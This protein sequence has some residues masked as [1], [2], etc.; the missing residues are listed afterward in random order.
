MPAWFR[1]GLLAPWPLSRLFKPL[2]VMAGRRNPTIRAAMAGTVAVTSVGMFSRGRSGWGIAATP[3]PLGLVVGS[4]ALKPAVVGGRIEPREILSCY[5]RSPSR[6]HWRTSTPCSHA[7]PG[8]P[9][10]GG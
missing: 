2:L 4:V 6:C 5:P 1:F 7:R 3:H 9:G 8:S 10:A